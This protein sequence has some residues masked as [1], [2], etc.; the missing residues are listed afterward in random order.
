VPQT[1]A[2]E[3]EHLGHDTQHVRERLEVR[4]HGLDAAPRQVAMTDLATLR[5]AHEACLAHGKRRE[6]V[7]QHE[8]LAALAGERVD[9]LRVAPSAEGSRDQR[10]RL[11]SGEDGGAVGA[12]QRAHLD[13][14][15]ADRLEIAAVDARLARED[16]VAN[17]AVL[18]VVQCGGDLV[19]GELRLIAA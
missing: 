7:V 11:A 6:V 10:L 18:E 9:N 14:D 16:H 2:I 8:W 5:G 12:R 19:L 15:R 3:L 17:Q 4:H 1:V 13:A